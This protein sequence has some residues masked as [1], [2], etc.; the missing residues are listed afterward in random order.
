MTTVP[1]VCLAKELKIP[2]Q[3]I[4]LVTDYDCWREGEEAVTFE[5]VLERMKNNSEKVKK[6]ILESLQEID[7]EF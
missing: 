7:N 1:E 5:M 4:N 3:V 6:V 2:Y